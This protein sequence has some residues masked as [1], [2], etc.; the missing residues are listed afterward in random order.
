MTSSFER[1]GSIRHA[2]LGL[3]LAL[4]LAGSA[5]LAEVT[6]R[7]EHRPAQRLLLASTTSTENSG[8]LG[9]ILPR[10]EKRS[11]IAVHVVAVGTGAALDLG[12]RCDA[13]ILLV[14]APEAERAYIRSGHGVDRRAVM[15]NDFVVAGPVG[16]PAGIAGITSVTDA[17]AGIA[18][19]RLPFV[20]RGD[21]SGTHK[22]ERALWRLL[23]PAVKYG[24]WYRETGA[25]MGATL[26]TAAA[27]QAYV[28]TDRA[29][30]VSFSNRGGLSLLLE[31]DP[32]LF[33]PYHVMRVNPARCPRSNM[34]GARVLA[35]WLVGAEGQAA[36]AAFTVNGQQLFHPDANSGAPPRGPGED[37]SE[38]GR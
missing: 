12:R 7:P 33:N 24:E 8:L 1:L 5:A 10:F 4:L 22:K 26:N 38:P 31:G 28:L 34:E 21:E 17:L 30:W 27:M 6:D 2:A 36:I 20:S 9:A 23:K 29:T 18:A 32:R 35:D 19:A 16:D 14:H 15:H 3:L 37:Q 11:G 25:G 13:D